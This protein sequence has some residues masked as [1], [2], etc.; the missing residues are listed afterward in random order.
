MFYERTTNEQGI[1]K[2]NINLEQGTYILTATNPATKEQYSNTI[3]VISKIQENS[4]LIKYYRNN[5]QYIAKIIKSD[6]NIAG[7]GEKVTFNING[8]FY[9]R[10]TNESGHVKLN[11]N[12]EPGEYIITAEYDGCKVS[13][14]ITVLT[15]IKTSNLVKKYSDRLPFTATI[16]DGEGNPLKD[17][18]VT[19]NINGVIYERTTNTYGQA[20][21]NINL[22]AGKYII[23]TTYNG[24]N[25]ANIITV[26]N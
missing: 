22:Q 12:L 18:K 19:F 15:T 16:L 9:E 24:L 7:A 1:A 13:N 2:L 26:R 21:L 14:N 23:T 25:T 17:T 3:T 20:R 8:V 5:S 4:N 6:G 10:Y 11:I